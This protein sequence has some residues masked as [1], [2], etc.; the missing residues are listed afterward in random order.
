MDD[1]FVTL[2]RAVDGAPAVAIAA[3]AAW[4]VLS[5]VLSPCHLASIP[6]VV[7]WLNGGEAVG[8]R[9]AVPVA[10]VFALGILV[11]IGIIGGLTAAAGRMLGDLGR[12]GD[13]IVAVVFLARRPRAAGGDWRAPSCWG[14]PSAR[15]WVPAPSPSWRR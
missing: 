11:T 1:L 3:A 15:P 2:T 6:L 7:G 9:R 12:W 4:G 13:V 10:L 5:I 8:A 14:W